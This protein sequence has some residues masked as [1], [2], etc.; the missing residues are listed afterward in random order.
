MK[1]I[2]WL[3][4][5]HLEFLRSN[6]KVKTLCKQIVDLTPD[7]VLIGGDISIAPQ[8]E[9]SIRLLETHLQLPIYFV[10]GNHDCYHGSIKQVRSI[11]ESLSKSSQW[12]HWLPLEGVVELS[13]TTGLIGHDSWADGRLGNGIASKVMLNDYVL[14]DEFVGLSV[15]ERFQKLNSLGDEAAI[16]V[17]N[18]LPKA[19][20]R[21]KD[22]ILL[23]H[24]PP[25]R[26]ACWHQGEISNDEFLP[27]FSC[28][29][30]GDELVKVMRSYPD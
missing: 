22:I 24:V 17:K 2:S 26:E 28:K 27:H 20:E 21:Y 14:I 23:T 19:L 29:V 16:Y 10:L 7:V 8:F 30:V 5:I 1:R 6:E 3:T 11:A 4:D 9:Q 12:L 15:E 13:S 18:I 25:F